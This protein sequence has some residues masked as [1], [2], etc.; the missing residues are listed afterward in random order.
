MTIKRY[1]PE[2]GKGTGGEHLPFARAVEADGWLYVSGQ[3]PMAN[4]DLV[5]GTIVA[6]SR[7]AIQN[8]LSILK[9]AGYGPEHVVRCGVWLDDPRDFQSFNAVFKEYFGEHPPARACVVSSMVV[10][11]KVE[12]ECVAYKAMIDPHSVFLLVSALIAVICLI[13]MVAVFK[14]NPFITLFVVSLALAVTTGMPFASVI[15]SFEAGMGGTLGHIAIIVALGTILGKMMAES[16]GSEQIAYTLIRLFG[17]KNI[18]WAMMVIGLVVGLPAF[19]EVGFVLLI[20][21][22]F[23]VARRTNTSLVLVGLPMVA[24]LSVV[25]GLVPPHPAAML[26]VATYKADVGR[27]IFYALIIGVPTAVIAGPLY[28]KLIA[29]HVQ[30]PATNPMAADFED[31]GARH[32]LPP[33]SIAL[34]TILLPVLLMLIG[35]WADVFARAGSGS[36]QAIRLIGNDDMALL[37][38]VLFSF[39]TLGR[40][41]GFSRE[42]ILRFSNECLAPTAMIT[43]LVGAGGGFGRVLQD[44]GVS[45]AIVSVAMLTHVPVLLLAWLLAA[46]MRLAT[47]SATVAMT[48]AAGIVAPIALH[49]AGVRP[50]LLA[51]ATGAGS[52][53]FSHVNDGGFWLVKEY[54]NMTV[55]QTIKTWS[56]CETIISVTALLFTLLLSMAV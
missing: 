36:N 15:R 6:Q 12:I 27:T 43:L 53:I 38:G 47:G 3:V 17:E 51:I 37:I 50:E 54:F 23:T 16:G 55:P 10:D 31:H 40:M 44:S 42:T 4:G 2:G 33:F 45:K 9:E 24:G 20:P 29:P 13:L 41:R 28:A 1:G 52:L 5:A 7:Q 22:A 14:L 46:L 34:L 56:M 25:H 35:S 39:F 32:A 19:F 49:S 21:I 8:L 11:C 18:P 48:T 26:A 30:L